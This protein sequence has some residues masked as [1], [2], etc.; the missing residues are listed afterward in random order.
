MSTGNMGNIL[1]SFKLID[2]VGMPSSSIA[3]ITTDNTR[4]PDNSIITPAWNTSTPQPNSWSGI[5]VSPRYKADPAEYRPCPFCGCKNLWHD[6][7]T[8][9]IECEACGTTAPEDKWNKRDRQTAADAILGI[10]H[11]LGEG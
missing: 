9:Q 4:P 6:T 11:R 8:D 7:A 5:A 10:K 3:V 2:S 1:G